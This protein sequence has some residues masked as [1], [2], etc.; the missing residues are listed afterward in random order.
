MGGRISHFCHGPS[1]KPR[2]RTAWPHQVPAAQGP[3]GMFVRR[4]GRRVIRLPNHHLPRKPRQ[5]HQCFPV[6]PCHVR[7]RVHV[8]R[9][10]LRVSSPPRGPPRLVRKIRQRRRNR[11]RIRDLHK[12]RVLALLAPT[13]GLLL[14]RKH[15][16]KQGVK[17][18]LVQPRIKPLANPVPNVVAHDRHTHLKGPR[19][20]GCHSH[21][22]KIISLS[23][24]LQ[25]SSSAARYGS[26]SPTHDACKRSLR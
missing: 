13:P 25:P 20:G 18:R 26:Q 2:L 7:L 15:L 12:H 10:R 6:Q 23:S 16:A 5:P 17:L 4:R 19:R 3:P 8:G 9:L 21:G 14:Q 1:F 24:S 22:P 11:F